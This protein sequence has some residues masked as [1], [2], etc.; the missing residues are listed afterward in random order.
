MIFD[1]DKTSRENILTADHAGNPNS[2]L[3][4]R[5]PQ[6]QILNTLPSFPLHP[7]IFISSSFIFNLSYLS[8]RFTMRTLFL[9]LLSLFFCQ[10]ASAAMGTS[11]LKVITALASRPSDIFESFQ[12][13]ICARGCKPTVPHW[14]LWTRNNSFVP[15]VHSITKR[16]NAPGQEAALIKLGDEAAETIKARCGPMIEGKDICTDAETLAGFGNCFKRQFVRSAIVNLH[17]LLPMA[18][19][20]ACREQYEYLKDDHLWTQI[21]PNNMREYAG[22]CGGLGKTTISHSEL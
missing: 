16:L 3:N 21:I 12:S 1:C 22:A 8:I 15:A 10:L 20:E 9:P 19:E 5:Q 17:V 13:E 14:D 11:C 6:L 2:G 18:S 4:P 7:S